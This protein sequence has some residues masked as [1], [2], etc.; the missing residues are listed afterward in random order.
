[1]A[2]T[3]DETTI[4]QRNV[5]Q[6]L[7]H[8]Q[9]SLNTLSFKLQKEREVQKGVNEYISE[10]F[11]SCSTSLADI[12]QR[13]KQKTAHLDDVSNRMVEHT[14]NFATHQKEIRTMLDQRDLQHNDLQS[15]CDASDIQIRQ[16]SMDADTGLACTDG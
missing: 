10:S 11:T 8:S 15:K 6:L 13:T 3:Q 12:D 1:L 7:E 4:H 16:R 9:Q 2:G 5:D 14:D